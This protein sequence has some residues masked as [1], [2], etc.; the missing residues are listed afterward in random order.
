MKFSPTLSKKTLRLL[1]GATAIA[2]AV[3][4]T[5]CGGG[6]SSS[7]TPSSQVAASYQVV[8]FG[9]SLSDVGTYAPNI[10]LEFGGGRFTTNPGQVWTQDVATYYGSTLTA[11]QTGGFGATVTN[12]PNGY[13]YG[14]GGALVD[15]AEGLGWAAN[16]AAALTVPVTQQVTN[17][18]TMHGSFTSNQIVLVEG[19]ANDILQQL[20]LLEASGTTQAAASAALTLA[21]EKFVGAIGTILQHGATKVV[22]VNVPDIGQTPLAGGNATTAAEISTLVSAYNQGVVQLLGIAG[23]T[24]DVVQVNAY[25]FIDNAV[26][27]YQADGFTVSNTD[28]ACNLQLMEQNAAAAGEADPSAF[29]S[30]LFC[31]PQVYKATNADQTYM[32]AD[33]IH[34]TTHLH[35]LFASYVEGIINQAYGLSK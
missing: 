5:A 34:P 23:L 20:E 2:F 27:N 11:A 12:N 33:T 7:S 18:L 26:A 6:G 13:G 35:A 8:S 28:T 30:S 31:S 29:A 32:F 17:Y 25:T 15:G 21:A 22:V 4:M 10:A 3:S 19:G 14:Q 24:N 16:G 9:T 1:Q